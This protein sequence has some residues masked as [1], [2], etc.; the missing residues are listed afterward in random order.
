MTFPVPGGATFLR[1]RSNLA[2]VANPA[3]ALA[4]LGGLV[5]VAS[6]GPAGFAL[7]NA[8]P[9]ILTWTAPNDGLLHWVVVMTYLRVTS[10]ETGGQVNLSW[11]DPGGNGT[12]T[13]LVNGGKGT[14]ATG[15][16][17][18]N[19]SVNAAVQAGTTITLLQATA[20]TAGAATIWAELWAM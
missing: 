14:G 10:A 7:Q 18:P 17:S 19:W 9:N 13:G 8:T 15:T 4:D 1:A 2:D 16:D 3:A 6:T 5:R 12:A 20:L 11:T